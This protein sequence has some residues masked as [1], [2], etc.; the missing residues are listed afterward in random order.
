MRVIL[1]TGDMYYYIIQNRHYVSNVNTRVHE[2]MCAIV[3]SRVKIY[4]N[5]HTQVLKHGGS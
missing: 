3:L 5:T 4:K 1:C 2:A